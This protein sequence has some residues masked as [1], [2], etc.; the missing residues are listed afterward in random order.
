MVWYGPPPSVAGRSGFLEKR[1]EEIL[2]EFIE[3]PYEKLVKQEATP[4]GGGRAA[5][6]S[7]RKDYKKSLRNSLKFLMKSL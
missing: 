3:I 4:Q 2:K 6:D 7:L 5:Q 1:P